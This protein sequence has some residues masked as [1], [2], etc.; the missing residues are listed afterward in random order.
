[1]PFSPAASVLIVFLSVPLVAAAQRAPGA[2]AEGELRAGI[3]R[4]EAQRQQLRSETT[5]KESERRELEQQLD[6]VRREQQVLGQRLAGIDQQIRQLE[7]A[8]LQAR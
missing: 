7:Q 4:L 5:R 2:P 6:R 3:A 1:M 8:L